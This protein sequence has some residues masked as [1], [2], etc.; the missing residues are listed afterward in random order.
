MLCVYN[1]FRGFAEHLITG[2]IMDWKRVLV[3]LLVALLLYAAPTAAEDTDDTEKKEPF[4]ALGLTMGASVEHVK[5]AF[6]E[7]GIQIQKQ[8][9]YWVFDETYHSERA[10][11]K[12]ADCKEGVFLGFNEG[13]LTGMKC[14][15]TEED[16]EQVGQALIPLLLDKYGIPAIYKCDHGHESGDE[17]E[18]FT[19]TGDM[20]GLGYIYVATPDVLAIFTIVCYDLSVYFCTQDLTYIKSSVLFEHLEE[21]RKEMEDAY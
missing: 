6:E 13:A 5:A 12:G 14:E 1:N 9:P 8:K 16:F 4:S 7:N 11:A 18:M 19:C 21:N 2:D 3:V 17:L 10:I 15:F 20:D